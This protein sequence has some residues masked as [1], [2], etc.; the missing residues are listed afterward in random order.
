MLLA[1]SVDSREAVNAI[2][3]L[4]AASGG[5]AD[6]ATIE[7]VA[8]DARAKAQAAY[9]LARA[10]LGVLNTAKPATELQALSDATKAELVKLPPANCIS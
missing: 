4:A 8:T 7:A 5:R 1:M 6:A 2:A 10:E 3:N 9:D